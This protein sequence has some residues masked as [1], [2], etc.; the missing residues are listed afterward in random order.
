M[1]KKEAKQY[2]C[3]IAATALEDEILYADWPCEDLD[4]EER[5]KVSE[6]LRDLIQELRS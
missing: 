3:Q 6:V 5:R 1:N 2:A 4:R